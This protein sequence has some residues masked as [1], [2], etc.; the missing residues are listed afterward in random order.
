MV[1]QQQLPSQ[2]PTFHLQLCW[3]ASVAQ[4]ISIHCVDI[5]RE[6]SLLLLLLVVVIAI[7]L[8]VVDDAIDLLGLMWLRQPKNKNMMMV[9]IAS[10][11]RGS[12]QKNNNQRFLPPR[13][14][15]RISKMPG[16]CSKAFLIYTPYIESLVSVKLQRD[17]FVS[18][19]DPQNF[20]S[21]SPHFKPYSR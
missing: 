17:G 19:F 16:S 9:L 12:F 1:H 8:F 11:F 5:S 20:K 7:V 2:N 21:V 14:S 15:Y 18:F 10:H 4:N 6:T 13:V 3:A